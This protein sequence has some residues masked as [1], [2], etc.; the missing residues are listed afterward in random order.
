LKRRALLISVSAALL[1]A[2]ELAVG[3]AASGCSE[4][5]DTG[6]RRVTLATRVELEAEARAPFTS[7]FGWQITL[8]QAFV[9][10]GE[11]RYFEGDPVTAW[12]WLAIGRAL[13]HPG[14]Y[15]QGGVIGE[16]LEP[17]SVDLFATPTALS[18]GQGVTGVARSARFAFHAPPVVPAATAL[19]RAVA[20][21]VGTAT[22]G[23]LSR[24][25]AIS[26]SAA[27]VADA[28][29]RPEVQG[30]V[31]T[32]GEIDADGTVVVVIRPTLWLDQ[33]DFSS[34]PESSDGAPVELLPGEIAHNAFVR[35][36]EKAAAYDFSFE[37]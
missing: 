27:D 25:F 32:G 8:E 19:C 14:H 18:A 7:G 30:S 15:Q 37:R 22:Q 13:A 34:V 17:T 29:G 6:G 24:P 21:V 5:P 1:L 23:A 36:L 26:A 2:A 20:R 35:G 9:S 11:L 28:S 33:I 12:R 3:L 16:M 4:A 10:I 31:F